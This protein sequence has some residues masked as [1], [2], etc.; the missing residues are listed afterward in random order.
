MTAVFNEGLAAHLA[1]GLTTVCHAWA[2]TRRD[3]KEFAFTD[4]DRPLRFAGL[5]FRAD[6]G[7]SALAL[8]QSTGLS[9]D[10]TEALGALSDASLREDEIEQGRFD[11]AEVRA[12]VVNWA[13]T[14]QHWLSFR[15]T[16]GELT[17]SDGAF[18]AELRGLTEAL[19]RPLGRVY[20]KPC[21]AVLG[22]GACRFNLGREG[23]F[24]TLDVAQVEKR[25]TF[26]WT[27]L[28]GFDP[29]W[30]TRGRF[31]VLS[32]P[33]TGLWQTI[34]A[35]RIEGETRV[36]ELWEPMKG[37][38]ETG[39]QVRLVA[40]CDKRQESC[41]LKFNNFVNFQGFPD[42]PGEDWSVAVPRS[43]GANTGGSRR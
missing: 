23:Y 2:I 3:G 31:E 17:R 4:H 41:R 29:D 35:D 30:F 28:L 26:R 18:R 10:N 19:N 25:R 22:D 36:I 34:K 12:W 21:T 11:G 1:G 37:A 24:R 40:G 20:Q 13:D 38:V 6:T 33:A 27:G 32:G 8:A 5:E 9:V 39:T 43:S 15:G 7:L 16:I 42:L 14:D